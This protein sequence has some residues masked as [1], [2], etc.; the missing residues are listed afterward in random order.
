[1]KY[2][3]SSPDRISGSKTLRC[4]CVVT[5]QCTSA[6]GVEP[7]TLVMQESVRLAIELAEITHRCAKEDRNAR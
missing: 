5:R 2:F 6:P 7:D 4:G 1:M 3:S